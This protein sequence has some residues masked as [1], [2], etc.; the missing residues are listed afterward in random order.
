MG[1]AAPPCGWHCEGCELAS[2]GCNG[3]RKNQG[4]PIWARDAGV[5][6][7]P[8]YECATAS[9]L[10]HCGL[11]PELPCDTFLN[12]RDPSMTEDEYQRSLRERLENLGIRAGNN[13]G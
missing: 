11:C 10:E 3:C 4:V 1:V 8:I 5:S 2:A 13:P 9:G 6:V 12:L 7:C